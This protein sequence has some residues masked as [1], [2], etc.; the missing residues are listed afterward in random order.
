M[1]MEMSED[2]DSEVLSTCTWSCTCKCTY[3]VHVHVYMSKVHR[4]VHVCTSSSAP[5]SGTLGTNS[6][7]LMGL[8]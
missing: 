7:A 8:Y 4:H 3:N 2:W 1:G 5:F 6:P